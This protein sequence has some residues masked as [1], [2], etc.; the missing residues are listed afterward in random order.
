MILVFAALVLFNGKDLGGWVQ[1]G[2][3]PSFSA[4]D[5]ELRTSGRGHVGNWIRTAGE[6]EDFKLKFEYR[7][8]Q[9][10]EAAVILRAPRSDRPQGGGIT[11]ILAHDFH[12]ETTPYITGGLAGWKSPLVTFP[13]SF[14]VWHQAEVELSAGRLV[15]KI[16]GKVVQDVLLKDR[17][18]PVPARGSIGFPDMGHRYALRN[19]SLEDLGR[20]TKLVELFNGRD[21]SG[22]EKRGDS[23]NWTVRGDGI[24]GSNGHSILYA[25][26]A[27]ENFELSAI[28]RSHNRTNS[29]IFLR[30]EPEG[31]NRGFEVQIYS[32]V[33]S[34]YPTG[35]VYGRQRSHVTADYEDRWF[36]M[37]IRVEGARCRVWLDGET[38]AEFDGLQEE[39]RKPGRIGLQIHMEDTSVEFRD[40]RVRPLP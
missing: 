7:L 14:E 2:P 18:A 23:G 26:G 29:G 1:E 9:W 13:P 20:P 24:E 8:A 27:F 32:P 12:N 28:V 33:D 3:R 6:Y 38:A 37:Q 4:E 35:S 22:W 19:I 10:A 5:G 21:L 15:V 31:K 25:P 34:V 39:L 30:G 17:P 40:L 16:D 36:L 11:V